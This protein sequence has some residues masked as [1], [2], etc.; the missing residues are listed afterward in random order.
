METQKCLEQILQWEDISINQKME[1]LQDYVGKRVY[2][3]LQEQIVICKALQPQQVSFSIHEAWVSDDKITSFLHAV[4]VK[5]SSV[6]TKTSSYTDMWWY[7]EET[8]ITNIIFS[9]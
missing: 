8:K 9:L 1:V 4:G 3:I 5:K 6:K 2:D 7:N